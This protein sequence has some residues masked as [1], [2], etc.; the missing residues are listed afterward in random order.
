[1]DTVTVKMPEPLARR[2]GI[3]ATRRH[4][5]RSAVVRSAVE[6]YLDADVY[7]VSNRPSTYDMVKEVAGTIEAPVDLSTSPK[8]LEGYGA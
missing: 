6:R 7:P 5:S 1:M 4:L 8:H 3:L 2:L